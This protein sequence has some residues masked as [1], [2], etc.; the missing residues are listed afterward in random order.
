MAD[1]MDAL[2]AKRGELIG[3]I[4]DRRWELKQLGEE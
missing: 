3:Q 1:V 4:A 2:T